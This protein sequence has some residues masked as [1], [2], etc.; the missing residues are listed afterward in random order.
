M[1]PEWV[2]M[3]DIFKTIILRKAKEKPDNGGIREK[4]D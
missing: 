4:F 1:A 3:P 2:E